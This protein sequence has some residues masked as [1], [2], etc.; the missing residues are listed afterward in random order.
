MVGFQGLMDFLV[1]VQVYLANSPC[2]NL[3]STI[4]STIRLLSTYAVAN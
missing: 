4:D 3:A 2:G 1:S